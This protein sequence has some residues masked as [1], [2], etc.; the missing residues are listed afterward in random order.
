MVACRGAPC[1][2]VPTLLFKRLWI[3]WIFRLWHLNV[4]QAL[5]DT[6][7]RRLALG[8]Q[9]NGRQRGGEGRMG[10]VFRGLFLFCFPAP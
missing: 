7:K 1:W 5:L 3:H 4:A 6:L 2:M 9:I 8:S 10:V